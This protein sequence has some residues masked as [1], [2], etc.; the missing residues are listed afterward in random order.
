MNQSDSVSEELMPHTVGERGRLRSDCLAVCAPGSALTVELLFERVLIEA[1]QNSAQASG[2]PLTTD[3]LYD[4]LIRAETSPIE[5]LLFLSPHTLFSLENPQ[6]SF[7][8]QVGLAPIIGEGATNW[9]LPTK[10]T[11]RG[12]RSLRFSFTPCVPG[13]DHARSPRTWGSLAPPS[14]FS[15]QK[16][17]PSRP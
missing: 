10:P 1:E 15:H 13:R 14:S 17:F 4:L 2:V 5:R 8:S 11:L 9:H 3:Q 12:R 16:H 7:D 6:E